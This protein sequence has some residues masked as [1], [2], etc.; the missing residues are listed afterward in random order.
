MEVALAANVAGTRA[1]EEQVRLLQGELV[2]V[3]EALLRKELQWQQEREALQAREGQQETGA[4]QERGQT[5][6]ADRCAE[7]DARL[8]DLE[9]E[10]GEQRQ[11]CQQLQAGL[12]A[13]QRQRQW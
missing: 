10:L 6:A 5:A 9:Q 4:E 11:Q 1:L 12:E 7:V 8:R 3:A 13:Q 2:A